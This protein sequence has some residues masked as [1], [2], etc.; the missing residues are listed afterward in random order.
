[1]TLIYDLSFEDYAARDAVNISSLKDMRRSPAHYLEAAAG[2]RK[3][4]RAKGLGAITH[5]AILEPERFERDFVCFDG[6]RRTKEWKQFAAEHA[7]YQI[8]S[9]S[10]YDAARAMRDAVHSHHA[11]STFLSQGRPEVSMFWADPVTG[12][13]TSGR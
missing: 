6:D 7:A 10:D 1:M 2:N 13:D 3:R 11:A 8:A 12:I 9:R 5:T 4:T